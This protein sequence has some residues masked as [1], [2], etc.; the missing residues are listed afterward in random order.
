MNHTPGQI[1]VSHPGGQTTQAGR[2]VTLTIN[3]NIIAD[4]DWNSPGDNE[5]TAARLARAWNCHQDLIDAL[6]DLLEADEAI[7]DNTGSK[8]DQAMSRIAAIDQARAAL[9]K[10]GGE[11]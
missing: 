2:R 3:G 4:C 5:E 1:E 6:Q 8:A 11:K 10:V 7:C 9:A